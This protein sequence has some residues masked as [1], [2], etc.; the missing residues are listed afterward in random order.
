MKKSIKKQK[1]QSEILLFSYFLFYGLQP[2]VVYYAGSVYGRITAML[3]TDL[4]Y[5][6]FLFV[7]CLPDLFAN[8][9]K[10]RIKDIKTVLLIV[11]ALFSMNIFFSFMTSFLKL[12]APEN[13]MQL[14]QL[15]ETAPVYFV[16]K[17]CLIGPFIEEMI[18]RYS[19]HKCF[20][21]PYRIYISGFLFGMMHMISTLLSGNYMNMIY[22][23]LYAG[24]GLLLS[25]VYEKNQNI[26]TVISGHAMYNLIAVMM[27]IFYG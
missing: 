8:L 15:F 26:F 9:E 21:Y 22:I 25:Y 13:E 20:S 6:L 4:L 24:T 10:C 23:V 27:V 16:L 14:M 1:K 7:M 12:T 5:V 11:V 17:A 18:F 3:I 2:L 19:V